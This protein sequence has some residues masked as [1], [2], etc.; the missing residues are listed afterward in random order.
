LLTLD[1]IPFMYFEKVVTMSVHAHGGSETQYSPNSV[2]RAG[3]LQCVGAAVHGVQL[4]NTD[5]ATPVEMPVSLSPDVER[6]DAEQDDASWQ[7]LT[8]APLPKI[9]YTSHKHG[10]ASG[11]TSVTILGNYF[12]NVTE[13]QFGRT[14]ASF[15]VAS[16]NRIVAVA[17]P[18]EPGV[19]GVRISTGVGTSEAVPFTFQAVPEVTALK[20]DHG[21]TRGGTLVIVH[22]SNFIAGQTKV[23]FGKRQGKDVKVLSSRLLVIK[24]P[25]DEPGNVPVVVTTL[26][27]VST[28]TSFVYE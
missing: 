17:P 10:P 2:R 11:G 12:T 22:G 21:P 6:S 23:Y 25:P 5:A 24:S 13:V 18:S 16:S 15:R 28:E 7:S 9:V 27:G 8:D 3:L 26:D 14:A 20:P 4:P 19:V 1:G